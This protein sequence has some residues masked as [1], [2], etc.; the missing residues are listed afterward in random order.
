MLVSTRSIELLIN[1][2]FG[3]SFAL[4]I[5]KINPRMLPL[6][7]GGEFSVFEKAPVLTFLMRSI[8]RI[9]TC[10][11]RGITCVRY[12]LKVSSFLIYGYRAIEV[13]K[14]LFDNDIYTANIF[15]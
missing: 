14:D 12:K 7:G 13:C 3:I 9:V 6:V 4:Q 10:K 8:R 2:E 15:K 1:C 5:S 11:K